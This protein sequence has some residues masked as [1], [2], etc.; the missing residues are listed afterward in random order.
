MLYN[1]FPFHIKNK[2]TSISVCN[3]FNISQHWAV[4]R[5]SW[6]PLE[7]MQAAFLVEELRTSTFIFLSCLRFLKIIF[8]YVWGFL[9][10]VYPQ[11]AS[12]GG[13]IT[14]TDYCRRYQSWEIHFLLDYNTI[15][16]ARQYWRWCHWYK[17]VDAQ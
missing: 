8:L 17:A 2:I 15:Y 6:Q 9:K 7:Y 14:T 5:F 4:Q 1:I 10:L 16:P 13:M 11:V 3:H 12:D